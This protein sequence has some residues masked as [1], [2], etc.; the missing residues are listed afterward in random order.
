MIW[1]KWGQQ[2]ALSNMYMRLTAVS[3]RDGAF[4][5]ISMP[6]TSLAAE[7]QVVGRSVHVRP[8]VLVPRRRRQ[9]QA[10]AGP[11]RRDRVAVGELH[12][13][14]D[15]YVV[16]IALPSASRLPERALDITAR[17][18]AMLPALQAAG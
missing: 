9:R 1:H 13:P 2:R 3:V 11:L 10:M 14:L 15:Q 17:A 8:R 12:L 5:S 7:A 6:H 18:W 16:A 4:G